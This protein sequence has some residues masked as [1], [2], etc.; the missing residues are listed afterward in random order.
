MSEEKP[1]IRAYVSSALFVYTTDSQHLIESIQNNPFGSKITPVLFEDFAR[2]PEKSLEN[3]QHV[4]M[5]GAL[6]ILKSMLMLAMEHK[7]G[8]GLLPLESQKELIGYLEAYKTRDKIIELALRE[9]TQSIDLILLNNK[10]LL[11]KAIIGRVPLLDSS[12]DVSFIEYIKKAVYKSASMKLLKFSF[13]TANEKKIST[14][15]SGCMI[16]QHYSKSIASKLIQHDSS[17]K[18]GAISLIIASP[19]STLDYFS[20]LIQAWRRRE[21]HKG[22]PN[23]IGYIKSSK[24][25]IESEEELAVSID[26]QKETTTPLVCEVVRDAVQVNFGE[27]LEL[28]KK[29]VQVA[30]ERIR[31]DNIPDENELQKVVGKKIPFFSYASE[32]RFRDLFLSLRNDATIDSAF[33]VL[34]LL[35]T[36]LATLGLFLDSAAVIIGAMLLAPLMSPIVSVSMGLLRQNNRLFDDS[37]KKIILGIFLA[38][39][40][41]MLISLMFPHKPV[42][43]EMLGRLN[44]TLLDLAVAI[45]S[46]IAAAYSKSY[47]EI[48]QSLAGVAIAVAIVPPLAVAG[49][50]LGQADIGFFL[51]A[52]LLFFTNLIGIIISAALTFRVLGYS[53]VVKSKRGALF[54]VLSLAAI[55]IPLY[56]SYNQIVNTIV[57][58]NRMEKERYLINGKYLIIN[59]ININ[60][61]KEKNIIDLSILTRDTLTRSDMAKLK[62]KIQSQSQKKLFIRTKIVHIL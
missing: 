9:D 51:Q 38:L 13:L 62:Q 23:G 56:I 54:V 8:V 57:L 37:I 12:S 42:T 36:T 21:S 59:D 26:G 61:I 11:S 47:K 4:V 17:N 29:Q 19:Y 58:K 30:K 2:D 48:M 46:G 18:D 10:I 45:V 32:E 5:S 60:Y 41:S 35:S 14:A 55:S 22:L 15:A 27:W 43:T 52:F 1:K 50:G 24:L 44:P 33:V 40:A 28:E 34:M 31:I 6:D 3:F 49:I 53:S 25:L 7:F 39:S 16:I 20:F